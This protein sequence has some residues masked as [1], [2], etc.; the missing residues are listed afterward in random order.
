MI[1]QDILVPNTFKSLK[2]VID[3][4]TVVAVDTEGGWNILMA[5]QFTVWR[6]ISTQTILDFYPEETTLVDRRI[7]TGPI[8]SKE[9]TKMMIIWKASPHPNQMI[10]MIRRNSW[11]VTRKLHVRKSVEKARY[12]VKSLAFASRKN[13]G[14]WIV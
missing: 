5:D 1:L 13:K 12:C 7:S 4:P 6:I 2:E 14:T 9:M 8:L 11:V 10:T 3:L